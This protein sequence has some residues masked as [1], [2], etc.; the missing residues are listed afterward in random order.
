MVRIE[1]QLT[2]CRRFCLSLQ[3]KLHAAGLLKLLLE[4]DFI[5]RNRVAVSGVLAL[6]VTN[7]VRRPTFTGSCCLSLSLSLSH[8]TLYVKQLCLGYVILAV[9]EQP[10][11]EEK[12]E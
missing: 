9:I 4:E 6:V 3:D 1:C 10:V 12:Q 11:K 2:F 7:L 5:N 8:L